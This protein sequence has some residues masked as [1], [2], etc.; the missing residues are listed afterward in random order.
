MDLHTFL[1]VY[2]P[3]YLES[4]DSGVPGTET[5]HP[6]RDKLFAIMN[7][8][9]DTPHAPHSPDVAD[10]Y[11]LRALDTLSENLDKRFNQVDSRLDKMEGRFEAM[12]SKDAFEAE[13]KRLDRENEIKQVEI[14]KLWAAR[15]DDREAATAA[16]ASKDTRFRWFVATGITLAAVASAVVFGVLNLTLVG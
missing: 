10:G 9:L 5:K 11:I 16:L 12:V 4:V 15:R 14:E 6:L 1:R 2:G 13:V 7:A 8:P 3:E